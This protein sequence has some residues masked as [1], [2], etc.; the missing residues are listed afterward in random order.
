MHPSRQRDE[1]TVG[2]SGEEGLEK[3]VRPMSQEE[4][5]AERRKVQE[6]RQRRA[7][8]DSSCMAV[9]CIAQRKKD[10]TLS[11]A[12]HSTTFIG[13]CCLRTGMEYA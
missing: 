3:A 2:G 1:L 8:S 4:R 6:E 11:C 5:D 12:N 10:V 13:V 9:T 7:V